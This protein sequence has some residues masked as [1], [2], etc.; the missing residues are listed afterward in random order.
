M[1]VDDRLSPRAAKVAPYRRGEVM[2]VSCDQVRECIAYGLITYL[3]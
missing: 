2:C 1:N 3:L